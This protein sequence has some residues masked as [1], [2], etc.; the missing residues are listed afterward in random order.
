MLYVYGPAERR[1]CD[2]ENVADYESAGLFQSSNSKSH[3]KKGRVRAQSGESRVRRYASVSTWN[4]KMP[5]WF[6]YSPKQR[7]R[8]QSRP[9]F[10]SANSVASARWACGPC[11]QR[12]AARASGTQQHARQ[13][14]R[15]LHPPRC[16]QASPLSTARPCRRCDA[17]AAVPCQAPTRCALVVCNIRQ[18]STARLAIHRASCAIFSKRVSSNRIYVADCVVM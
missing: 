1:Q 8:R 10:Q 15:I 17:S 6:S 16:P 3:Q 12:Q 2:S 9:C 13:C 14:S 18:C 11:G 7:C 4:P 5:T